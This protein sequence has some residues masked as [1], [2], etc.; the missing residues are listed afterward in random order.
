MQVKTVQQKEL[1][2][3]F[4]ILYDSGS[5]GILINTRAVPLGAT[6]TFSANK[7]ITTMANGTFDTPRSV[8]LDQIRLPEFTNSRCIKG[9][10]AKLFD[11][12]TCRYDVILGRDFLRAAGIR[13]C[14]NTGNVQWMD[15]IM[16]M[17]TVSFYEAQG[18]YADFEDFEEEEDR[19]LLSAEGRQIYWICRAYQKVSPQE[20]AE[21]Q[22]HL[23]AEERQKFQQVLEK[24]VEVFDGKLGCYPHEKIKIRLKSGARLVHKRPY[25]VPYVREDTVKCELKHLVQESVLRP[26]GATD[27]AFPTFII[28]K[29]DYS[30]LGQ[31]FS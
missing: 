29:K 23:S 22:S 28:P 21:A 6:P 15:R 20:C 25:T 12:S 4:I 13:L 14:F 27:W 1:G 8:W 7:Q 26:C 19:E 17:E 30:T 10:Q 16:Q 31:R 2:R 3:P 24:Y 18:L 11:S 5:D 9:V